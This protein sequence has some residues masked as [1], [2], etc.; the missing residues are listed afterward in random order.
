M[1]E[2]EIGQRNETVLNYGT[3]IFVVLTSPFQMITFTGHSRYY[4]VGYFDI[5]HTIPY[6]FNIPGPTV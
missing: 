1:R 2:K 5:L 4:D 6:F 3:C